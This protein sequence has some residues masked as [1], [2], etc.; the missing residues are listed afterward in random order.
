MK[1]LI[2]TYPILYH[3]TQYKV[4]EELPAND[5]PMMDAWLA[6]GTAKWIDK[7]SESPKAKPATAKP[8]TAEPGFA[9]KSDN[10]ET[11]EN[12]VGKVPETPAR[13]KGKKN[14]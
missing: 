12:L 8:A 7:D 11:D 13:N 1:K 6:A 14:G 2:A 4:G 10:S 9:G 5:K 3:A